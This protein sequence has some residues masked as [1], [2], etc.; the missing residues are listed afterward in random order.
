MFGLRSKRG[1]FDEETE[2]PTSLAELSQA[3]PQLEVSEG[4]ELEA[5]EDAEDWSDQHY[6][7]EVAAMLEEAIADI[8]AFG[9]ELA[10]DEVG[11]G[12]DPEL[13]AHLILDPKGKL[14]CIVEGAVED[15][16]YEQVAKLFE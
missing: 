2:E 6:G 7:P 9:P 12:A 14:R 13:P 1:K 4:E 15:D 11:V 16:D 5:L 10:L 8:L 3:A